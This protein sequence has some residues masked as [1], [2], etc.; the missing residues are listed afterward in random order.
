[1]GYLFQLRRARPLYFPLWTLTW[2]EWHKGTCLRLIRA[3]ILSKGLSLT[4]I[5]LM[6]L[7]W[8]I[9]IAW[10]EP[11]LAQFW[12]KESCVAIFQSTVEKGSQKVALQENLI[13]LRGRD[14]FLK[15]IT[16]KLLSLVLYDMDISLPNLLWKAIVPMSSFLHK[17]FLR[18]SRRNQCT[19]SNLGRLSMKL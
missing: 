11:Q 9:S 1:M 15:L 16:L 14:G 13:G 7:I 4:L 18:L 17:V 12:S 3:T 8:C 10:E 19:F 6:C 2:Q 5:V